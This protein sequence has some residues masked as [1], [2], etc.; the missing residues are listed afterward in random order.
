MDFKKWVKSIQTAGYN[1]ERTVY[2][3]Y[4]TWNFYSA[5][6]VEVNCFYAQNSTHILKIDCFSSSILEETRKKIKETS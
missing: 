5:I 2:K 4:S 3:N 6:I 1:G